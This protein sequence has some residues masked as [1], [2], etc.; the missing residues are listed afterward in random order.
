MPEV[1]L[2]EEIY[3]SPKTIEWTVPN[4]FLLPNRIGFSIASPIFTFRE[5]S[6]RLLALPNGTDCLPGVTIVML[7]GIGKIGRVHWE[8]Q[9]HRTDF[10]LLRKAEG[11]KTDGHTEEM[12]MFIMY[13]EI[14]KGCYDRGFFS[15]T[16]KLS[17]ENDTRGE[18]TYKGSSTQTESTSSKYTAVLN[19]NLNRIIYF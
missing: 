13:K 15:I 12:N 8:L 3:S 4:F 16:C 19:A 7:T 1:G 9:I 17:S 18:L 6:C 2:I 5:H 10:T 14:E 11:V